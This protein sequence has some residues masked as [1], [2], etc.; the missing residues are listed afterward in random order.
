MK[1]DARA[2]VREAKF[3]ADIPKHA[4]VVQMLG[5]CDDPAC[6]VLE[7]VEGVEDLDKYLMM[8]H[9]DITNACTWDHHVKKSSYIAKAI[10]LMLDIARG[11]DHLHS[12]GFVHRDIAGR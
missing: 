7:Y 9:L 11:L 3:M 6:M 2:M 4:D 1:G 8:V 5:V 12:H 10:T